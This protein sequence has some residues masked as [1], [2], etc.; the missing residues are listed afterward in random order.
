M[1]CSATEQPFCCNLI[2]ACASGCCAREPLHKNAALSMR[3]K[4]ELGI[5]AVPAYYFTARHS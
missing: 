3:R 4:M 5:R 1:G 2:A